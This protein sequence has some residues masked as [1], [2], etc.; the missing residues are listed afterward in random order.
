MRRLG[1]QE[2]CRFSWGGW[3]VSKSRTSK[4]QSD[5]IDA[6]RLSDIRHQTKRYFFGSLTLG[7]MSIRA[8]DHSHF[9]KYAS[10]KTALRIIES[11]SFRWSSPTKFNDPF[12][13]QAGLVLNFSPESFSQSLTSSIERVIFSDTEPSIT[14]TTL[15][16]ALTLKLRQVRH[17]LPRSEILRDL[18]KY[19]AESAAILNDSIGQLNAAIQEQ[20]CHSRVFCVSEKL[21]NVVMWSHYADQHKGVVFK[22]RCIDEIDNTLLGARKVQYTDAFLPFPDADAYAR[23]LIGE[24]PIDFAS[25]AWNIAYTKHI[26][27]GYEEEWR[28]HM[29]LLHEPPGDGYSLY[30]ENPRIFEA[31]YLGCRMEEGDSKRIIDLVHRLLPETEVFVGEKSASSFSLSFSRLT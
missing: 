8:H 12:D 19:S 18:H 16:S 6:A 7:F 4:N 11:K 28:V 23:H 5:G 31:I 22:L 21:D 29:P 15:F 30:P 1:S 3:C 9:F 26:D 20:L 2:R 27:W 25:L 14:P 17:K 24:Q 13:H 10:F